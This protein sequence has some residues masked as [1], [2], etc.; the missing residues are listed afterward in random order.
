MSENVP[1]PGPIAGA[2]LPWPSLGRWWPSRLVATAEEDRVSTTIWSGG[3]AV[4]LYLGQHKWQPRD[5]GLPLRLKTLVPSMPL[6]QYRNPT[7][8]RRPFNAPRRTS[9]AWGVIR[10]AA[11]LDPTRPMRPWPGGP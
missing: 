2:G 4:G 8:I 3:A 10:W 7:W 9:P 1:V 11:A 6:P 5:T